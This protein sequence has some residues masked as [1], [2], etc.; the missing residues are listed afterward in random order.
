MGALDW[1]LF[2]GQ[3]KKIQPSSEVARAYSNYP[4]QFNTVAICREVSEQKDR[5]ICIGGG[6]RS[7]AQVRKKHVHIVQ[8]NNRA[9]AYGQ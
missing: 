6:A 5:S 4:N 8:A 3:I 1:N 7:A 9:S 2:K